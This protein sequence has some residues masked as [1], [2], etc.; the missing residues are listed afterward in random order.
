MLPVPIPHVLVIDTQ[1]RGTECSTSLLC[2]PEKPEQKDIDTT[3][4]AIQREPLLSPSCLFLKFLRFQST[5]SKHNASFN[6]SVAQSKSCDNAKV[7]N[8]FETAKRKVEKVYEA[9][10]FGL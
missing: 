9:Y 3:A 10:F 1:K 6:M 4:H 2:G 5:R 7:D 8:Y